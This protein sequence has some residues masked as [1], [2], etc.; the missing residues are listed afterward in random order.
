MR[1]SVFIFMCLIIAVFSIQ[2]GESRF[3]LKTMVQNSNYD[4]SGLSLSTDNRTGA[5]GGLVVVFYPMDFLLIEC[6]ALYSIGG[7]KYQEITGENEITLTMVKVPVLLTVAPTAYIAVYA[8]PCANF[9][10]KAEDA[11]D[12]NL[13][14]TFEPLTF[15]LHAGVQ[16]S[17][18]DSI[19]VDLRYLKGLSNASKIDGIEMK[20]RT[21]ALGVG[22]L[23]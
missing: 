1:K 18:T 21:I 14:K 19:Y 7:Y 17:F 13:E 10:V 3:G 11:N 2:A 12:N 8:G 22:L 15:S 6:E 20:E 23:F 9:L 4:I 16:F 5:A